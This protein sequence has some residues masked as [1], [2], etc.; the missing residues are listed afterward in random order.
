MSIV[1]QSCSIGHKHRQAAGSEDVGHRGEKCVRRMWAEDKD[2]TVGC[3]VCVCV[4]VGGG[5]FCKVWGWFRSMVPGGVGVLG[6][7]GLLYSLWVIPVHGTRELRRVKETS[8]LTW[9]MDFKTKFISW[10][11]AAVAMWMRSALFWNITQR[12]VAIPHR[13]FGT[14]YHPRNRLSRNVG[15]GLPLYAA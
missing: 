11:Q 3:S 13:R 1:L 15:K 9:P 4:C 12:R 10:F 14:T 6:G 7:G 8:L 2:D 5:G